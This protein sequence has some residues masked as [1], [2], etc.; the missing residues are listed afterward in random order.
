MWER[1]GD[2]SRVTHLEGRPCAC[3][4]T[5]GSVPAG[6]AHRRV[7][8]LD[9]KRSAWLAG[10]RDVTGTTRGRDAGGRV[11]VGTTRRQRCAMLCCGRRAAGRLLVVA[12]D[13]GPWTLVIL[14]PRVC[15]SVAE[16]RSGGLARAAARRGFRSDSRRLRQRPQGF[17]PL[18]LGRE[19]LNDES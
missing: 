18:A 7:S 11:A 9:A 1:L 8:S 5:A 6:P 10:R 2:L 16:I 14:E 3:L 4:R 12:P 15:A 17:L 19:R 13:A